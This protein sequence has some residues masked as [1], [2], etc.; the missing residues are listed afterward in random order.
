MGG[1]KKFRLVFQNADNIDFFIKVFCWIA[2]NE[3]R[4]STMLKFKQLSYI[5]SSTAL[6]KNS[7]K[8]ERA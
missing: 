5:V 1:S 2:D 8:V 3:M 7:Y 4:T 6:A